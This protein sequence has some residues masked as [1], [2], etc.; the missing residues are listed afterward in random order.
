MYL[1]Y[2]LRC[3]LLFILKLRDKKG[4]IVFNKIYNNFG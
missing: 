2:V 3:F 4:I 1:F